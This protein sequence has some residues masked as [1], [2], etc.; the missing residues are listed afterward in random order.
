MPQIGFINSD[1]EW[2]QHGVRYLIS[3]EPEGSL[4]RIGRWIP[5]STSDLG[6]EWGGT[7]VWVREQGAEIAKAIWFHN[8]FDRVIEVSWSG[9]TADEK[10]D[11]DAWLKD[12]AERHAERSKIEGDEYDARKVKYG[13]NHHRVEEKMGMQAYYKSRMSC[14][15]ECGEQHPKF[16][17]SQCKT[18][19]EY[20]GPR[21]SHC[22]FVD[23]IGLRRLLQPGL[24]VRGLESE[25]GYFDSEATHAYLDDSITRLTAGR[26][27]LFL[28]SV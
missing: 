2:A 12:R 24:S 5:L 16:T 28:K 19:R 4:Y 10:Q 9:M 15:A 26:R 7:E 23:A 22:N 27:S 20:L 11:L 3:P 14:R 13:A 25:S 8:H 6:S 1:G 17:C 21:H 18:A